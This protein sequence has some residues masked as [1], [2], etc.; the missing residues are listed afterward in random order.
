MASKKKVINIETLEIFRSIGQAASHYK[1]THNGIVNA[2]IYGTKVKGNRVEFF[3]DWIFW[4][5]K[6]KEKYTRKYNIYFY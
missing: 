5:N 4:T 1:V 6:D 2:I 3:E